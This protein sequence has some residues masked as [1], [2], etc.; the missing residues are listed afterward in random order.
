MH[1]RKGSVEKGPTNSEAT[2]FVA[3]DYILLTYP[4][5]P[6]N[7]VAGIYRGP[8]VITSIDR[9]DLVKVRNLITN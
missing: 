4:N 6:P 1:Q 7:K 3:G 5:C 2:K 8:M 9:P